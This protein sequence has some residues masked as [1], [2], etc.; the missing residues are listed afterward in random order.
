MT[1]EAAIYD[2]MNGF[3]IPAYPSSS[4]P[5]QD[6]PGW[7]GFPYF[8]YDLAVGDWTGGEV[9]MPVSLYDRTSSEKALN[10]RVRELSHVIGEGGTML[11]CDDGVVWLKRGYPWAQS[12][13]ISE[14]DSEVKRRYINID[15]EFFT[16]P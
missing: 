4:V 9:N 10:D 1:P 14:E 11:H 13:S 8:T 5:E 2:F 7:Q 6:G 12:V 15:M 3:G 16:T